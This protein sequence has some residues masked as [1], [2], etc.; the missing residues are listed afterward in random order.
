M[1]ILK[2]MEKCAK[3]TMLILTPG[4]R[5]TIVDFLQ[6]CIEDLS[7]DLEECITKEEYEECAVLKEK[8]ETATKLEQ[9]VKDAHLPEVN[10]YKVYE[11]HSLSLLYG[12][13]NI[14][15][16]LQKN[17]QKE[18]L[19]E[20]HSIQERI[21]RTIQEIHQILSIL[22]YQEDINEV[23]VVE[24]MLQDKKRT[25]DRLINDERESIGSVLVKKIGWWVLYWKQLL[26]M[27]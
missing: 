18:R 4:E 14:A 27:Q 22:D 1:G 25:I 21:T 17:Y 26:K 2:N 10:Q 20:L 6:E 15:F 13:R 19:E 5:C 16:S 3:D 9:D 23:A 12:K 7:D 8:I 11:S 24:S